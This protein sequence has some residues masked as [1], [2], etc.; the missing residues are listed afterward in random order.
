MRLHAM[1]TLPS[2]LLLAVLLVAAAAAPA[3]MAAGAGVELNT[4]TQPAEVDLPIYPGA[5]IR[6][7][8]GDDGNGL[9]FSLWGGSIGFKL[10]LLKYRSTASVDYVAGFYRKA[11]AR[12]GEVL[13][14]SG[15]QP[16][17]KAAPSGDKKAL[18]CGDGKAEAGGRVY[19][20]GTGEHQRVVSIKAV[21][22]QVEF[23]LVRLDTSP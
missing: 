8:K 23:D 13:D 10:A 7:D 20:A 14:C 18:T 1:P 17:A 2:T 9:S 11:L 19:K 16:M 22:Q 15:T 12:H 6:R 5:T 21:G 3:A 4:D